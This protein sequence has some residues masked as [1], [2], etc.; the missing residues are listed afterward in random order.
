M[1]LL[2]FCYSLVLRS[3]II[4]WIAIKRL[5]DGHGGSWRCLGERYVVGKELKVIAGEFSTRRICYGFAMVLLWFCYG[6]AMVLLYRSNII[7][8]IAI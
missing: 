8:W 5:G 2:W 7:S 4:S 6:F 1:V 3:N